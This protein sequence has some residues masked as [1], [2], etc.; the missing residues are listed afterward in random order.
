MATNND[1]QNQTKLNLL[2]ELESLYK[3]IAHLKIQISAVRA[4]DVLSSIDNQDSQLL[5]N[6]LNTITPKFQTHEAVDR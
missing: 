1:I 2:D 4:S 3:T 5:Y 6:K